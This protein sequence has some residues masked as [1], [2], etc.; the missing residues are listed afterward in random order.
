MEI[1]NSRTHSSSEAAIMLSAPNEKE[2]KFLQSKDKSD[3]Y[4]Q[5]LRLLDISDSPV[6]IDVGANI[7]MFSVSMAKHIGA[8]AKIYAFEPFH[9]PFEHL[10]KNVADMPVEPIN[11][12]V[13]AAEKTITGSYLPNYTLLSGFY[14]DEHDKAVLEELAHRALDKEFTV[15][16][17]EVEAIRLDTFMT[18]RGIT[19]VDILKIDAEK[20]EL[21]VLHSLGAMLANVQC[22]IAEV[23]E[24]HI[25]DFVAILKG[26]YADVEV[27]VPDLPKFCLDGTT[28]E[29]W[30]TELNTYIVFAH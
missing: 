12:A 24:L 9:E 28:P 16:K 1:A 7:G 22:I 11:K 17:E 4:M 30:P 5:H 18:S 19:R 14:V 8:H 6:V 15:I 2:M 27:S 21:D 13:M 26:R 23:H 29:T 20:S 10:V 3:E 25:K